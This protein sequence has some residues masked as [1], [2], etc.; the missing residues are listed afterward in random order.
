VRARARAETTGAILRA[1]RRAI[2]EHGGGALSMR[3][4]AREVGLVSSAVYRYFPTR[5]ALLT[6]MIVESYGH[7][8]HRLD[9]VVAQQP[10]RRWEALGRALRDW[11]REAP[12]EFQLI[13]GTPVPGYVAP[14]ETVPAAE[15]VAMPFL[16]A[17]AARAVAGFDDG[18][19]TDQV[20]EVADAAGLDA[21]G[22]A[23]T[24]A[25][26]AALVG[27]VTLELGGHFVGTADPADLLYD[28]LLGRQC[29]T[30]GLRD[31]RR[32]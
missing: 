5:E 19:L 6:T 17:G 29:S 4:V 30:L 2:A 13:Y 32:G 16:S 15:A 1:A 27:F 28:A 22:V 3:A 31:E 26:L 24:L 9:A 11:A 25:E 7:L 12:H 23:A 21:S 20:R 18:R 8:A 14:P 10:D